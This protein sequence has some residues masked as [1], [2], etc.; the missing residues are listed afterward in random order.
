MT[1]D[2]RFECPYEPPSLREPGARHV[3]SRLVEPEDTFTQ[4]AAGLRAEGDEL[5]ASLEALAGRLLDAL[6]DCTNVIRSGGGLLGRGER[7]VAGVEVEVG[8][9]KYVLG[10]RDGQ[11]VASCERQVGGVTADR[12][13]LPPDE[14]LEELEAD[15]RTEAARN[16]SARL[17]LERLRR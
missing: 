9:N 5:L 2:D 3:P 13:E 7:R 14:W 10:L 8:A 4:A 11:L 6:P 15:L 16:A 1:L 12:F 17:G